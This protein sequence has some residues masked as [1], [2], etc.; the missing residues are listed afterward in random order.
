MPIY[1]MREDDLPQACFEIALLKLQCY[2]WW[3]R[4]LKTLRK[5]FLE[6]LEIATGQV[7]K[8]LYYDKKSKKPKRRGIS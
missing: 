5:Q 6:L 4:Q 7:G 3:A 1:D 2:K 8:D